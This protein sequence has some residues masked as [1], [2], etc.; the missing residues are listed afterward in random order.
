MRLW[1]GLLLALVA[2]VSCSIVNAPDEPTS[3]D[4][5]GGG[6]SGAGS[7]GDGVIDQSV[8]ETCDPPSTCPS[9][10][11]GDVCTNDQ[12]AGSA[13]TC[14]VVCTNTAITACD[15][16]A[17]GCCPAGCTGNDDP[18]CASC[19]NGVVELGETCD[20]NCP[21]NC[22]DAN[23]CTADAITGSAAGCDVV[24]SNTAITTCI[25]GDG[26]CAAGCTLQNDDDCSLEVALVHAVPSNYAVDIQ[27][28]LLAFN[29]FDTVDI[30]D[31]SATTPS[32]AALSNYDAILVFSDFG[33]V[34]PVALGNVVADYYDAGGRVVTATFARCGGLE[35]QGRFGDPGQGYVL[36]AAGPQ[37]QPTDNL[38]FVAEPASPLMMGVTQLSAPS[39]Y[40]CTGPVANGGIVVAFWATGGNPLVVRGVVQGRNRVDL[41]FYPPSNAVTSSFWSGDGAQ[42]MRNALLF[43]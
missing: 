24:C 17:D 22:D 33:F 23:A 41:N 7:C 6:A 34:D 29:V 35:I 43:Q 28:K 38:G 3:E 1:F 16:T 5:D 39:A 18:D 11:D 2:C 42:L 15:S 36:L 25:N 26:C 20:G 12:V 13:S 9:C 27:T 19:G 37:N 31:A 21:A 8:G 10:D 14:D 4:D 30:L 32:L 40:R